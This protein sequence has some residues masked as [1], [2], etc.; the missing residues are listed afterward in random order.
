ME[1]SEFISGGYYVVKP[2]S[3]PEVFSTLLP[4][5]ILT[6][7]SCIA[8]IAPDFWAVEGYK[9]TEEKR[10]AEAFKFGIP[11]SLVPEMTK[12][13]TAETHYWQPIGFSSAIATQEFRSRFI[14]DPDIVVVG[15]GLHISRLSSFRNQLDQD[16]NHG[17]G[18]LERIEENTMLAAGGHVLGFEPLGYEGAHFHSWLCN[19]VPDDA[20]NR[21]GIRPNDQGFINEFEDAVRVVEYMKE[22][23]AEPAIWEPWLVVQYPND[24]LS[25][26]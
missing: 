11:A 15:I 6:L 9:Y 5:N 13:V 23:G 12:W 19:D 20:H 3:R 26:S 7:S 18:L 8:E 14:T 1:V 2:V 21:F 4:R 24:P 16:I 25:V 17:Y 22:T 10:T